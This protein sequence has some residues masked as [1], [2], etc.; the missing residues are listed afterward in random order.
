MSVCVHEMAAGTCADCAPRPQQLA[1]YYTGQ[2]D[3]APDRTAHIPGPCDERPKGDDGWGVIA[4]KK[5]AWQRIRNGD[6]LATTG[7]ASL[8]A[9]KICKSCLDRAGGG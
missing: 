4:G 8:L 3:V 7:G 2:V 5:D 1:N 9:N 6:S